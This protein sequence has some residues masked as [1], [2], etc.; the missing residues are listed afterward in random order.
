MG[1]G[2]GAGVSPGAGMGKGAPESPLAARGKGMGLAGGMP[3]IGMGVPC[4][5]TSASGAT[6][7]GAPRIEG[8]ISG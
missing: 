3:G 2:A 1:M 4:S 6:G 7:A 5:G 8:G